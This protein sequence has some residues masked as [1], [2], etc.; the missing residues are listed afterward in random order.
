M[1]QNAAYG[2]THPLC[3]GKEEADMKWR[4]WQSSWD[5]VSLCPALELAPV[6]PVLRVR[7]WTLRS[8]HQGLSWLDK[9]P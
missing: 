4:R 2:T 8:Q 6:V 9:E 7:V 3:F 5:P 1:C